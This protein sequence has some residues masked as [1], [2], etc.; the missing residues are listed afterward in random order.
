MEVEIIELSEFE[1][2]AT[3]K[4][5]QTNKV[6][7][8]SI[9]QVIKDK[10]KKTKI[11]RI[12]LKLIFWKKR[13]K[14]TINNNNP[15]NFITNLFSTIFIKTKYIFYFINLP[16]IFSSTIFSSPFNLFVN[17]STNNPE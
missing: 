9:L 4:M 2:N 5:V 17:I 15:K 1:N 7:K 3:P 13:K 11:G 14:G 16:E 6:R 12:K 8:L 10:K